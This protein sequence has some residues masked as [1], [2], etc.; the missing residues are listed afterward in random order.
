MTVGNYLAVANKKLGQAGVGTARLDALVL[1]EDVM[2]V[3]RARLLAEPATEISA[4]QA[5]K[6]TKLLKRR[7]RHEPLAYVRGRTEFY[8]R[9][10]VITPTVLVPRPESEAVIDMFKELVADGALKP[11]SDNKGIRLRVADVGTG[12]GALGITAA[13]EVPEITVDLLDIDPK[14]LKIAKIN[15]DKFTLKAEV[16]RSDL[17]AS[18]S[19]D[20]DIVLCNLPYVPDDYQI[21]RAAA[22]EPRL[23]I[24]GGPDGIDVYRRLFKQLSQLPKQPLYIL[25]E[26]LPPQH[27]QLSDIAARS[28]YQV[29][30]QNSFIQQFV[31]T[32]N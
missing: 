12:S 25:T 26:A 7:A 29:Q 19:Q 22:K 1:L 31:R 6:L 20:Y 32:N 3:D 8:G 21:N 4:G 15:V 11:R 13:L 27:Q 10:F 16:G 9:D 23:A 17:L 18:S 28:G 5:A 24:F 30:R 2:S 14:A